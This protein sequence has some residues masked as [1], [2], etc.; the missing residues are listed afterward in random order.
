[1]CT[2]Y[3]GCYGG[4]GSYYSGCGSYYSG[5]GSYYSG[6]GSSSSG[7][8]STA[9]SGCGGCGDCGSA[10]TATT[11]TAR[12]LEVNN[13]SL[14]VCDQSTCQQVQV[15]TANACCYQVGQRLSIQYDGA[16]TNSIPPQISATSICRIC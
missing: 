5:C 8:G 10:T 15:N 16:M 7:C 12:V 2:T 13:G 3:S 14:L 11:M 9:S 4:C 6:C 1:M